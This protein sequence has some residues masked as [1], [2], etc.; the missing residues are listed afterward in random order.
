MITTSIRLY[1]PAAIIYILV[2][3]GKYHDVSED[4]HWAPFINATVNYINQKYP[5]PWDEATE[6]LVVFMF[7]V[8]SHQVADILWHS[9]GIE[10]GFIQT[11]AN[12]REHLFCRAQCIITVKFC[13]TTTLLKRPS[14]KSDSKM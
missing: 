13:L 8:V 14:T 12:V 10:Q 9:L 1:I 2:I 3:I 6:K 5:K 7:G 11:M 4:T